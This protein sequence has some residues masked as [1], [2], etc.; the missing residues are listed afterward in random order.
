MSFQCRQA[1]ALVS[2]RADW[3]TEVSVQP[4]PFSPTHPSALHTCVLLLGFCNLYFVQDTIQSVALIRHI[5][6]KLMSA[7]NLFKTLANRTTSSTDHPETSLQLAGCLRLWNSSW[8]WVTIRVHNHARVWPAATAAF[9]SSVFCRQSI[10]LAAN[11]APKADFCSKNK[12]SVK[13]TGKT[14]KQASVSCQT[15]LV[16]ELDT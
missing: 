10:L 7:T 11:A 4:Q 5:S 3:S 6:S 9:S 13:E 2:L 14:A 8:N 15:A 16:A 1:M 12:T